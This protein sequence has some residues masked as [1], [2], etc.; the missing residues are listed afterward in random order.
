MSEVTKR[1][2]GDVVGVGGAHHQQVQG[3]P[4]QRPTGG[5]QRWGAHCLLHSS[6]NGK[7]RNEEVVGINGSHEDLVLCELDDLSVMVVN[8]F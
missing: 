3:G 7:A 5:T 8:I 2:V 4:Q 6:E 1:V